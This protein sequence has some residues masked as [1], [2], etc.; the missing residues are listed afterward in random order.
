[1]YLKLQDGYKNMI[2]RRTQNTVDA[3]SFLFNYLTSYS[4]D[5]KLLPQKLIV[6]L[7]CCL[8]D[9]LIRRS[10]EPVC[11]QL[12]VITRETGNI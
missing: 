3:L 12:I 4:M 5:K 9:L 6:K 2:T 1:M 8:K 11:C 10:A 7:F